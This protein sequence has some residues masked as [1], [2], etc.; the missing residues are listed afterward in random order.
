MRLVAVCVASPWLLLL[1]GCGGQVPGEPS[2]VGAD[3]SSTD[4]PANPND[5]A[6]DASSPSADGE[7]CLGLGQACTEG[8]GCCVG[9]C[10]YDVDCRLGPD[11]PCDPN[12]DWCAGPF[13][14]DPATKKCAL[15]ACWNEINATACVMAPTVPCCDPAMSC[16]KLGTLAGYGCCYPDGTAVTVSQEVHCCGNTITT[17]PD[18]GFQCATTP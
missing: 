6:P 11:D 5:A 13:Q 16:H 12:I 2:D 18:G 1:Q 15:P 3:A 7:A 17:S 9:S 4:A 8:L 14:C 10:Q